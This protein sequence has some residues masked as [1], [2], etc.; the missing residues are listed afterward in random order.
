[1]SLAANADDVRIW[2]NVRDRFPHPYTLDD[3]R[4]WIGVASTADPTTDLAIV[5]DGAAVGGIGLVLGQDIGR[6]SA[7][8]GYW[9]G[10]DHWGRGLATQ[11]VRA[12]TA[13]AFERFAIQRL[14]AMVL[15]WNPASARVLEKA[16]YQFEARARRAAIKDGR[17]MDMLVYAMVRD[18]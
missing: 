3:A 17:V 15:E 12:F 1:M 4:Q 6:V 9:L 14:F 2:R 13:W 7:E 18:G 5:V 10:A 8:I 16:G 11:A